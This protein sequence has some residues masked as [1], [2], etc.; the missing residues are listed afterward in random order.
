MNPQETY[1]AVHVCVLNYLVHFELI[2]ALAVIASLKTYAF[3]N[4]N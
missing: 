2:R 1:N 4:E 3:K